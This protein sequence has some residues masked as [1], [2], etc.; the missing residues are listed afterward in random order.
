MITTRT[1]NIINWV[2]TGIVGLIFIG[3]SMSKFFGSE[4]AIQ[5][6][7]GIGLS[8]ETFKM[9]GTIELISALLFIFPR[10]GIVGTLLLAAYMGGAMATHLTHGLSMLAPATIEA[11]IWVVAV[12]RFPELKT[13]LLRTNQ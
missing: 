10:T 13:R 12:V 7:K 4:E 2:L 5:M 11:I 1:K 8:V 3:S 9:L 6:A